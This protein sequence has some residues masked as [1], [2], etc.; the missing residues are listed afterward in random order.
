MT[1]GTVSREFIEVSAGQKIEKGDHFIRFGGVR[2]PSS[3]EST[4]LFTMFTYDSN[5]Y[6]VGKGNISNVEMNVQ[7]QFKK[8]TIEP[9]NKTN[10]AITKY[11]IAF[12][13]NVALG[14]DDNL[15]ITFPVEV[16]APKEPVC[17]AIACVQNV[18]C[19]SEAKAVIVLLV[20]PSCTYTSEIKF[21]IDG[22]RNPYS[23][24]PS[25]ATL[26]RI[27]SSMF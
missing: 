3:F 9:E 16:A 11:T 2:N 7:R 27:E 12:I 26:A 15:I 10:G 25:F 23:M 20:N 17:E 24:V 14:D 6:M 22:M 1:L 19:I 18:Q 21:A 8:M 4:S 5:S 13:P